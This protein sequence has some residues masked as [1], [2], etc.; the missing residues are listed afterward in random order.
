[1]NGTVVVVGAGPAGLMAGLAAARAGARVR[2][3]AKGW[4]LFHW[5]AG[6]VDVLGYDPV[7]GGRI[8]SLRE[9]LAAL[10]AARP[11]HPYGLVG[12]DGVLAALADVSTVCAAAGYPLVGSFDRNRLVLT[13]VGGARPTCLAP[14]TMAAGDLDRGDPAVIVGFDRF[15]D[16]TAGLVA[17]NLEHRGIP[18][19]AVTLD[20]P[21]LRGRRFVNGPILAALF[22]T[23][24]FRAEVAAVL[25]PKVGRAGRV[26][27][28]AVLGLEGAAAVV[29]D[30]RRRLGVDVFEIPVA[31]PSIP[32]I[33]LHRILVAAIR[34]AGGR[35]HDGMEAVGSES[36]ER[37]VTALLTESAARNLRT[38]ADA[39]VLATGGILGGGIVGH[40]DGELTE[41]V[42]G[43]PVNGPGD[44]ADWLRPD[45]TDPAG[46]PVY[47][48]GLTVDAELRP[49][50]DDGMP[51]FGNVHVAG[52]AIGGADAI[53]ERSVD[54]IA[55]ATGRYA[56]TLA[57]ATALDRSEEAAAS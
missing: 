54:G 22:E 23:E 36:A 40:E 17:A 12:V 53:A 1:M 5:H 13:G 11:D 10:I 14:A 26:G 28:P 33:R 46:H 34:A 43:L 57:A 25:S 51:V 32:G 18:S 16:L 27:F 24:S 50:G 48:S 15:L 49:V 9:G 31:P 52:G 39:F 30:L 8:V 42:F 37:R 29:A 55:L 41:V 20:L 38:R 4:G 45:F 3:L 35:V 2:V 44:R 6:C 19:R 47:R 7:G 21:S 56:G